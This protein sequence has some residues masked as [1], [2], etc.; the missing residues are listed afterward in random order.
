MPKLHRKR[1]LLAKI[2]SSYNTD[3]NPTGSS[4]YVEVVDLEVEPLA[5]DEV[6]IETIRP[7]AGNYPRLLA[8]TRVNLSFGV[9]MVG[10]GSAGTSPKYDSI[11]KSCGL[12]A[13]TVTSTSVT[14]T[15]STL[16]TQDSC[17]LHVNYDGVL[18]KITGARGTFSI[19]CNVNEIPRINFEMQGIFV[20]PTDTA[21]PTVDKTL[22]PD[23][24][25]FKNG[26]TS[27]FSVHGFSAALQSWEL[28]F[29]NEVIYRELVGGT[30]EALITDRRPSG[31]MVV[32]AVALSDKN[33]FTAATSTS[34]GTN[35]W[36][37]GTT[38]GNIVTV[39]CPQTDLGQ[40]TYEENDGITMLNL[41]F[42][43]TPTDAGQ[44]EFSLAF[45]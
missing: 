14:Y 43:A 41:P 44:D 5:S 37:H 15:P 40:P 34:T 17:T 20:A 18:H 6:E 2:E 36:V 31:T 22:Q 33:F 45:T 42:Y 32:E 23:G 4:D 10:S 38:A 19:V 3:S 39:S 8:N 9:F 30:K 16:A 26:N 12:S 27:S 7:Y 28:D 21:L 11:L 29:A 24:I 1:S 13:N 25:L 35:T